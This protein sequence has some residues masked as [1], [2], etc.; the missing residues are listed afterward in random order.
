DSGDARAPAPEP[1]TPDPAASPGLE[2]RDTTAFALRQTS[3]PPH[4]PGRGWPAAPVAASGRSGP[5]PACS[6]SGRQYSH[7]AATRYSRVHYGPPGGGWAR[8]RAAPAVRAG[9]PGPAPSAVCLG[10][11]RTDTVPGALQRAAGSPRPAHIRPAPGY[12]SAPPL[13][14]Q[15]LWWKPTRPP[16]PSA[17]P[18]PAGSGW[19]SQGGSQGAPV[20][21]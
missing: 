5:C 9:R 15:S 11:N 4:P 13:G 16:G 2:S 1:G 8:R 17:G 14:P 18:A 19:G 20:P 3:T 7:P 10:Y 21:G 6:A 12:R